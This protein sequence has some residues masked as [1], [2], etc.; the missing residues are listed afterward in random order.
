[1]GLHLV[2]NSM[3]KTRK[4]KKALKKLIKSS[5]KGAIS[6]LELPE[7][8][9]RVKKIISTNSKK[10]AGEFATLLKKARKS[11][12]KADKSVG[13]MEDVILG[14]SRDN[15]ERKEKKEKKEKNAV[16]L[17]PAQA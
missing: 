17:A 6:A 14:K 7:A 4:S 10:L 9:K 16:A 12:K 3:E 2:T 15:K 1:L 11:A 13:Y 5:V 8:N